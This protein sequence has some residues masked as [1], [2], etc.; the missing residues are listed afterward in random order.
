MSKKLSMDVE[1]HERQRSELKIIETFQSIFKRFS[2]I[3]SPIKLHGKPMTE[4]PAS[5][6]TSSLVALRETTFNDLRSMA[7]PTVDA[8]KTFDC[9]S[10]CSPSR[11]NGVR[12]GTR[13]HTGDNSTRR[14]K[15]ARAMSLEQVAGASEESSELFANLCHCFEKGISTTD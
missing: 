7:F 4:W 1:L 15:R 9:L 5:T 13:K 3:F 14:A 6:S 2:E 12:N 10:P 11:G 8:W